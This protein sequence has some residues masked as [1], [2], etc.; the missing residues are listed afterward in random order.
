MP[1][2]VLIDNTTFAAAGRSF[3]RYHPKAEGGHHARSYYTRYHDARALDLQSTAEFLTAMVLFDV[4]RWDAASASQEAPGQ[5]KDEFWLYSWFPIFNT[6]SETGVIQEFE[7][8]YVSGDRLD[9]A[10]QLAF[11][12]VQ[13]QIV[14]GR[15]QLSQAFRVPLCYYADDYNEREPFEELNEESNDPLEEDDLAL[16]MFLHRGLYYQSYTYG[17][18]HW[19][20]HH[21]GWSYLPHLHRASLL[22]SPSW[23]LLSTIC[24]D[25]TLWYGKREI[26]ASEIL[27]E[28]DSRF[29]MAIDKA[30]KINPLP[31]GVALGAAF[32]QGHRRD[33]I[34]WIYEALEFRESRSGTEI[35]D[36][37][38]D[39][40]A[41]GTISNKQGIQDRLKDLDKLL[42]DASRNHFGTSWAPDEKASFMLGL[43][44]SWQDLV[45]PVL[46]MI[47]RRTREALTRVL[48]SPI[49]AHG[50]QLLFTRYLSASR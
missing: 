10:R 2:T 22:N 34:A 14:T 15:H 38:R 8:R 24:N 25:D 17:P 39:L 36:F 43:S 20:K 49:R 4:L 5:W 7:E 3:Y 28:L 30:I 33:P 26:S 29:F 40:L 16:A 27:H 1:S 6:A 35:R 45:S 9:L 48:Y 50:F 37:F 47:P 21:D 23:N 31:G 42:Q 11:K 18:T 12:W 46:E 41:L 32:M 19:L 13:E 44:G